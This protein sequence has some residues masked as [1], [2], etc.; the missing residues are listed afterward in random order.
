[1]QRHISEALK[2]FEKVEGDL[3]DSENPSLFDCFHDL[4][5]QVTLTSHMLGDKMKVRKHT[6][7]L[8]MFQARRA[9]TSEMTLPV[10]EGYVCYIGI[11]L[12]L[13]KPKGM[14]LGLKLHTYSF[15]TKYIY[16]AKA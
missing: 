2:I 16:K 12:D 3:Y 11:D 14:P 10:P 1:M 6:I 9:T 8:V 13:S 4:R 5:E 7:P 15:T